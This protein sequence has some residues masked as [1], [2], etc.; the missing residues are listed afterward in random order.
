MGR[1]KQALLHRADDGA[2]PESLL[3]HATRAA[4]ES[5]MRPICV[6]LGADA[7]VLAPQLTDLP[8]HV[9]AHSEWARG[10]GSSLKAGLEC[11]T[12]LAPALDAVII[13]VCDQPHLTSA[14]LTRLGRAYRGSD[15]PIVASTYAGTAGVPALFD[16]AVFDELHALGDRDGARRVIELDGERVTTV[17]FPLGAVDVD[18]PEEYEAY[19]RGER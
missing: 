13:T 5:G 19:V 18:T 3:R 16:R 6:V 17:P 11:V 4:V 9:L 8:V 14:V 2:R 7:D 1:S 12:A 10:I 15:V